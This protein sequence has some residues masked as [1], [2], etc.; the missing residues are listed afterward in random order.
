MN[1]AARRYLAPYASLRLT[2]VLM[3]MATFLVFAGTVAQIDKGIW[4]VVD[5]YFRCPVAWLDLQIFFPRD[6]NVPFGF[7]FPGGWLIGGA[8]FANILACSLATA[9]S[10]GDT[11]DDTTCCLTSV[12][13]SP[14][15]E[16]V[17]GECVALP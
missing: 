10:G 3:A 11:W 9:A 15:E 7:W 6:W 2:V 1:S 17:G 8:L 12:D 16:C 13:C 4:T 5:E 14:F